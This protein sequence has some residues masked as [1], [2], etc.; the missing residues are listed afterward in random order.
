MT[1]EYDQA[2]DEPQ[3]ARCA[4]ARPLVP[5]LGEIEK[6]RKQEE[7]VADDY[8]SCRTWRSDTGSCREA[9]V[10]VAAAHPS[11]KCRASTRRRTTIPATVRADPDSAGRVLVIEGEAVRRDDWSIGSARARRRTT[12]PDDSDADRMS[13]H[14]PSRRRPADNR[15]I[16]RVDRRR[17]SPA[18][19]PTTWCRE[20]EPRRQVDV[21]AETVGTDRRVGTA[22]GVDEHVTGKAQSSAPQNASRQR[23]VT[24]AVDHAPLFDV[25]AGRRA[26]GVRTAAARTPPTARSACPAVPPRDSM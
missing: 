4:L 16:R 7:R 9:R 17:S 12:A 10:S 3:Q 15:R 20:T 11:L 21:V 22:G 6:R 8:T 25:I 26:G 13:I 5:L 24:R 1:R 14:P 19:P 2:G 18:P 23:P